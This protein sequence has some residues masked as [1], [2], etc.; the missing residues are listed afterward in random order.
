MRDDIGRNA[1]EQ[2]ATDRPAI[3][4]ADNDHIG[5]FGRGRLEDP[6]PRIALPDQKLGGNAVLPG[7][8]HDPRERALAIRSDL[9][10]A[11]QE[12]AARQSE[13]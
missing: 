4:A 1:A 9:V 8:L 12:P 5:P 7:V 6:V 3:V 13:P 10:D 11:G 2:Q